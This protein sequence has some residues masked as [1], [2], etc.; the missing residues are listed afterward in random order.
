M[1]FQNEIQLLPNQSNK[2]GKSKQRK[3]LIK[4]KK[5]QILFPKKVSRI[6]QSDHFSLFFVQFNCPFTIGVCVCESIRNSILLIKISSSLGSCC[7]QHN[8]NRNFLSSKNT[9]CEMKIFF[10]QIVTNGLHYLLSKMKNLN[11]DQYLGSKKN[12]VGLKIYFY[13]W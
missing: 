10:C 12:N 5:N 7:N 6:D 4:N 3:F 11:Y 9:N 1:I 8:H 2:T 13:F